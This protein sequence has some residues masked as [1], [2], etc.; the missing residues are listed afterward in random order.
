MRLRSFGPIL[1]LLGC[2]PTAIPGNSAPADAG[3]DVPGADVIAVDIPAA[4]VP[5]A[6][7][8]ATD[9]PVPP[10]V[11]VVDVP[12][13]QDLPTTD[14]VDVPPADAPA[15]TCTSNAQCASPRAT[16]DRARGVCVECTT[17][18]PCATG[19]TCASGRCVPS[20]QCTSS[21]MC[22]GQVCDTAASRCVDCVSGADCAGGELCRGNLCV[23]PPRMCRS[24]RECSELDQVCH[25]TMNVCVDCAADND[26]PNGFCAPDNTCRPRACTPNQRTCADATRVRV[27]DARGAGVTDTPCGTS[28]VCSGGQCLPRVC[29]PGATDC[30]M[31]GARRTCNAD[32][33]GYTTARC[34][35]TQICAGGQCLD[36]CPG[37]L[38]R[39]G[40]ACVDLRTDANHCGGCGVRCGAGEVCAAAREGCM[41]ACVPAT[42]V[43]AIAGTTLSVRLP[44]SLAVRATNP[45][46]GGRGVA[47][48][49]AANNIA[50]LIGRTGALT[51]ADLSE[52][53]VRIEGP[54]A[55]S[56]VVRSLL[57]GQR[58]RLA[59]GEEA[60]TERLVAPCT[61]ATALRDRVASALSLPTAGATVGLGS[62][63]VVEFTVTRRASAEIIVSLAV[64]D[65]ATWSSSEA[66]ARRL[67]DLA[68]YGL[69]QATGTPA[70]VCA[71]LRA[72]A[73][74]PAD[75]AW[76]QDTSASLTPYQTRVGRAAPSLIERLTAAA[77]DA[78]VAV[79]Q[80]NFRAQNLDSP[81]L[82]WVNVS[83]T[84][85]GY[86]LCDRLTSTG[87]A[88]CPLVVP[89]LS[90]IAGPY[91]NMGAAGS[92]NEEPI[93]ASITNFTT[94][95]TRAAMGEPNADRRVRAGAR[96]I[97]IGLTDETGSNDY[98]RYFMAGTSPDT[99][100]LWG[101]PWST[102]VLSNIAA[103]FTRNSVLPLGFY[104]HRTSRCGVDVFD[105]PR[106]V[107]SAASGAYAEL[108]TTNDA[109]TNATMAAYGDA[110]AAEASTMRLTA[111][112]VGGLARVTLRGAEVPRSRFDG[113][114]IDPVR[115]AL[116]FYGARYRPAPGD[117]ITVTFPAW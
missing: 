25:P 61:S 16:C 26:C 30:A 9:T 98:G 82:T 104:P 101:S 20:V 59:D 112:P 14:A 84:N 39:C 3:A 4:D 111:V 38:L 11:I 60:M 12:A 102:I 8:V 86:Y 28:E 93:A 95:I 29:A 32:G 115:R 68:V 62:E 5:G 47:G 67:R 79:I 50:F 90:D 83:A 44:A 13:P 117:A 91:P 99:M 52:A 35:G 37:G 97:A 2:T 7:A 106:C 45:A 33:L 76:M 107:A 54:I 18:V 92:T 41:A 23:P 15:T 73:P 110:I 21:R 70:A 114:E 100:A 31:D 116:V 43:T 108:A 57:A 71:S 55:Q 46:G 24:S 88:T 75:I 36:G 56:S 27:C 48:E 49:D 51:S 66:A 10:D 109:D 42:T 89:G 40:T 74:A 96:R 19:S 65:R 34:P 17:T 78:R 69:P 77:L 103:W 105:L 6:D 63:C 58:L 87:V 113:Y 1:V 72:T 80:A 53:A 64:I 85:A 22:P 94:L 81:G